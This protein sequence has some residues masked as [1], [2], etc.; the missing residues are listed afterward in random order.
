MLPIIVDA[1]HPT[2]QADLVPAVCRAAVAIGADG[3]MVEAHPDPHAALCDGAQS[4]D[5][6]GLRDLVAELK[7]VAEAV[8]RTLAVS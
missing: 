2:G 7:P 3:L 1:S 4:L 8:G 6:D 5:M